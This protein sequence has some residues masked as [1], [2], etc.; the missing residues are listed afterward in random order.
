MGEFNRNLLPDSTA[1]HEGTGEP[2]SGPGAWGTKACP[3]HGGSDSMRVN[4]KSGGW[5][6]MACGEKGGD[7]LDFQMK[8]HGLDFIEAARSLG[9]YVEDGEPHRGRST[10]T[11]LPAREAMELAAKAMLVALVVTSDIRRGVIPSGADWLAFLEAAGQVEAIAMEYR[12]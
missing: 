5:R 4:R 8:L 3:F 9:A 1:Y 7:I 6:C 2:L 11:T 12:T 10:Q